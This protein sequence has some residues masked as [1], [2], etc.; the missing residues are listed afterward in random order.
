[1][2]HDALGGP[3]GPL[4]FPS[5]FTVPE[6]ADLLKVK[7]ADVRR[8]ARAHEIAAVWVGGEFRLLT[9]DIIAWLMLQR[10][11]GVERYG[12]KRRR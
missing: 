8:M 6:L 1:M 3:I 5:F 4:P 2:N 9:K 11:M 7:V 12:R 10:S